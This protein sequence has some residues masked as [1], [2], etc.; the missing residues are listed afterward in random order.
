VLNSCKG[1]RRGWA[2]FLKRISILICVSAICCAGT[3]KPPTVQNYGDISGDNLVK[4]I[5][6]V[7]GKVIGF[8]TLR[9][10]V[11]FFVDTLGNIVTAGH[12]L[13][14]TENDSVI[15]CW[16]AIPLKQRSADR[17]GLNVRYDL[18]LL[19]TKLLKND[20]WTPVIFADDSTF[21]DYRTKVWIQT[22]DYEDSC[23]RP[24]EGWISNIKQ[25]LLHIE[26][27]EGA[28][29]T[30]GCSGSPVYA[31]GPNLVI[32]SITTG[33]LVGPEKKKKALTA[34]AIEAKYVKEFLDQEGV[35]FEQR[36]GQTLTLDIPSSE[37]TE[38]EKKIGFTSKLDLIKS[39][40]QDVVTKYDQF[41]EKLDTDV[42]FETLLETE[43]FA[44]K[45]SSKEYKIKDS[46]RENAI[47]FYIKGLGMK[48]ARQKGIDASIEYFERS[49]YE[50]STFPEARYQMA[51]YH[52][53][54]TDDTITALR[55]LRS[56]LRYEPENGEVL[57]VL[58]MYYLHYPMNDSAEVYVEKAANS[59]YLKEKDP[60][61][62]F[63]RG[64]CL[65]PY[66]KIVPEMAK[67]GVDFKKKHE[68]EPT[69]HE[70][71]RQRQSFL[72]Q[73]VGEPITRDSLLNKAIE[74]YQRSWDLSGKRYIRPL[75]MIVWVI[76][77]ELLDYSPTDTS[78]S[79]QLRKN[80]HD[81]EMFVDFGLVDPRFFNTL[82]LGEAAVYTVL[83]NQQDRKMSCL[84][85]QRSEES[86][87]GM[88][89]SPTY[90]SD[91][92]RE[93]ER[94]R[95]ICDCYESK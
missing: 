8:D 90:E 84:Y 11:G 63:Y 13:A 55:H 35:K 61:I 29:L 74:D 71:G 18:G 50:D 57:R 22:Y 76:T 73:A 82:A 85:M 38:E 94:V 83:K 23:P 4:N 41:E 75:N 7:Q 37:R 47:S 5:I 70:I 53:R 56:A 45:I 95:E 67:W 16:D 64:L 88:H 44:Q 34:Y 58:A 15:S 28:E 93:N 32:G 17:K 24:I 33:A 14:N 26:Y 3:T 27:K 68:R 1:F 30:E 20:P 92:K 12:N 78:K 59:L 19:K 79:L 48:A 43:S 25:H 69:S 10:G 21:Y 81:M 66:W 49:A 86:L 2:S 39:M 40:M 89:L 77:N 80:L 46:R 6:R 62:E 72:Q 87:R 52:I 54:C 60:R 31:A 36:H 9:S 42:L 51:L 91:V 65:D